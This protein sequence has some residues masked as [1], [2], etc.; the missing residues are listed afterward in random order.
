MHLNKKP[1]QWRVAPLRSIL[2]AVAGRAIRSR[3][4]NAGVASGP[5][6]AAPARSGSPDAPESGGIILCW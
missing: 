6:G 4:G 2:S 1:G 3:E 5:E